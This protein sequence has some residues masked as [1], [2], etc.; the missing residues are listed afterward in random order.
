MSLLDHEKK[1]VRKEAAWV[2]SNIAAGTQAQIGQVLSN[3]RMQDVLNL[4]LN[5][6]WEIRKECIWV[7]SNIASGGSDEQVAS[8]VSLGAIH[9]L[10]TVLDMN[11]TKMTIVAL[12]A[13][14]SILEVGD[15][16]GHEYVAFLD[17]SN[18]ISAIESLQEHESE[19]VYNKAL[20]IIEKFLGVDDEEEE[21][22]APE[23][24][25]DTFSFGVNP[26]KLCPTNDNV[27]QHTTF[28]FA[29]I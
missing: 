2:L 8:L 16:Q 6:V 17:E 28:N 12:E 9:S 23:V 27:M 7:L 14:E 24:D 3:G 19:Q 21:N 1:N 26:A 11:D 22:L 5:A 20:E 13:I 18:G 10:V 4:S 29:A 25:G 15:R